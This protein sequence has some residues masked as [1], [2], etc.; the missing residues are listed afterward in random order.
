MSHKTFFNLFIQKKKIRP[1][2]GNYKC[3]A[4]ANVLDKPQKQCESGQIF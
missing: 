4:V 2:P 1:L 3:A